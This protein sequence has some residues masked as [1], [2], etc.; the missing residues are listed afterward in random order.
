MQLTERSNLSDLFLGRVQ[1][2]PDLPAYRQFDGKSW[3]DWTWAEVAQEVGRWQAALRA[4]GLQPGDRVALC[5]HNRIEWVLFDQ[6]AIGLRLVTV[7]L[8]F[9]DRAENM[10]WCLND[11]GARLLLL[12]DG[13]QWAALKDQLPTVERVVCLDDAV[14]PDAKLRRLSDWLPLGLHALTHSNAPAN[15][16]A[17]IV[18]TSGTTG[19][20]KGVMLSH[21]NVV[22]NCVASTR[23]IPVT[24]ADKFLSFL[25]LSH[26]F[27]RTAGYYAGIWSGA[28]TIYARSISLLGDDLR[29]QRPTI[30]VAVPRIFERIWSRMQEAMP[31]GT[32]KR[33]LFDKAVAVGWRRFTG[34]ATLVDHLWWPLLKLLVARKLRARMGGRIRLIVVGGAA[35]PEALAKIFISLGLPIIQGYGLTETAPVLACNREGDNDPASVGRALEGILLRCDDNGE[36]LARGLNIMLGYWNNAEA[37]AK[38]MTADGWFRTGDL[39][40]IRD[41]R[42]YITGRVK[43]IIVMSNG[44]KI[45]PADAEQAILRD[46]TFEQVM[47]VGEGRKALGLVCVAKID[48]LGQLCTRANTQLSGFPG[49][50]RIRH[51]IRVTDT[52]SV[53]NGLLTPTL[54]IRRKEV[55]RRYADEIEAMYQSTDYCHVKS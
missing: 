20:S 36:L 14:A 32:L 34:A 35:F 41:G 5:L 25:P 18:Y 3:R 19:R 48:D 1:E 2:T 7:P 44:E 11:A 33:R 47:I 39:A 4:E 50:A 22:T 29:Q 53:E 30:L 43:D 13:A 10:A 12:E 15:E 27:E 52:W 6:A 37:T 17:T 23:A 49:Y 51:I 24:S 8:Y 21:H 55:E 26:M 16:L 45:S 54:K 40:R 9:D 38:V 28:H 46:S 42:V 31:A